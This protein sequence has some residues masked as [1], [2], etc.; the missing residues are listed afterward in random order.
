[1]VSITGF[2]FCAAIIFIAGK[3]LSYYG[4]IIAELTGLGR[5]DPSGIGHFIT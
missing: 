1:M 4:N 3:K 2:L 5:V